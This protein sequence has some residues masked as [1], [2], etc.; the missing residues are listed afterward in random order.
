[1]AIT[2]SISFLSN[3][4]SA[5]AF[6]DVFTWQPEPFGPLRP[7]GDQDRLIAGSFKILQGNVPILTDGDVAV[8]VEVGHLQDLSKL[9]AQALFH[10]MF[11]W[12]NA[13]F[14]QA[15]RLDIPVDHGHTGATARQL[16]SG[17]QPCRAS[18]D[19]DHRL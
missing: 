12:I 13:V 8:I 17:V 5:D 11:G 16:A 14:R 6:G 1:L 19:D 18:P 15:P 7:G 4:T 10:F 2:Y 3:L 9:L